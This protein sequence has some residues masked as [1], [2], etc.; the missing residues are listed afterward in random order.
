MFVN[1]YSSFMDFCITVIIIFGFFKGL[2]FRKKFG[3]VHLYDSNKQITTYIIVLGVYALL[4][5]FQFFYFLF[6]PLV[7]SD[8]NISYLSLTTMVF[9][10]IN[11]MHSILPIIF[12]FAFCFT[13]LKRNTG[14]IED[15]LITNPFDSDIQG[16]ETA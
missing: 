13:W 9:N 16:I 10:I 11:I 15:N 3:Q 14:V 6:C 4:Y 8:P 7:R 12:F 5:V 1:Y 2:T